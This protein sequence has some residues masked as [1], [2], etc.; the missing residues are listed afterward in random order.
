MIRDKGTAAAAFLAIICL[1]VAAFFIGKIVLQERE[2][3]KGNAVYD[4]ITEAAS[5]G[6]EAPENGPESSECPHYPYSYDSS[7]SYDFFDNSDSSNRIGEQNLSEWEESYVPE[8]DF[9]AL[10]QVSGNLIAWL[11]LPGS[12]I[13]YPVAQC[14]NNSY[15]LKHL[16]DGTVNSSGCLFLDYK[17]DREFTDDNSIIYGHHMKNGSM[18]GSL[19]RYS[20]QKFY[21]SHP[22]LYLVT[23]PDRYRIEVFSAYTTSKDSDAY[24][25]RFSDRQEYG[26]WIE[27]I[28]ARSDI[29]T[30]VQVT[31]E[32]RILTLS[33]CAYSFRNARFVVHGKLVSTT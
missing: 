1:F 14:D 19:D 2:Y 25:L 21:N 29:K 10:D 5:A 15:Y 9:H 31:T 17:N 3:S 30:N 7:G 20:R 28:K 6:K 11:Y 16:A 33:T 22:S 4:Q 8:I 18:F 23:Q 27:R 32:D 12:V 26:E 13:N 24:T